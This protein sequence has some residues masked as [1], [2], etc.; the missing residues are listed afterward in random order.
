MQLHMAWTVLA[1]ALHDGRSGRGGLTRT[2]ERKTHGSQVGGSSCRIR[3]R[4]MN[5]IANLKAEED[6][7]VEGRVVP[8]A[9]RK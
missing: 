7:N 1:Q 6:D 9:V 4:L 2:Y 5:S 8:V 3:V